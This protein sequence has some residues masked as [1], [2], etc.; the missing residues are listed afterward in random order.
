[1]RETAPILRRR[2]CIPETLS[3]LHMER[4]TGTA[5]PRLASPHLISP[6]IRLLMCACIC[7]EAFPDSRW[8]RLP[9]MY[10][11]ASALLGPPPRPAALPLGR[12]PDTVRADGYM[13]ACRSVDNKKPEN[14][15]CLIRAPSSTPP[16]SGHAAS[17]MIHPPDAPV[18]RLARHGK[19][20]PS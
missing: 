5:S 20:K 16:C 9:P 8:S 3:P 6:L 12:R 1:M 15:F 7:R 11:L 18:G 4:R 2:D 10:Q 17:G 13:R 19:Q 14:R